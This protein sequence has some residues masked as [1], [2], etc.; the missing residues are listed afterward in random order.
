LKEAIK[1]GNKNREK[2]FEATNVH[3]GSGVLQDVNKSF[4]LEKNK[5]INLE[6]Y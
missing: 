3:N 6:A 5:S 1:E 2:P 4:T